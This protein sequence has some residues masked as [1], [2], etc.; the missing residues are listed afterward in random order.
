MEQGRKED[1]IPQDQNKLKGNEEANEALKM[2]FFL[3]L[4]LSDV[5]NR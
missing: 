3:Q 1:I 5:G 2:N 4:L